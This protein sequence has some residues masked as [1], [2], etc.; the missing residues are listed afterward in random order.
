MNDLTQ[1]L[2][3]G[4]PQAFADLY[5]AMADQLHHYLTARTG[6]TED[7][8][9]LLQ[10]TFSR[11]F[12]ARGRLSRVESLTAYVFQTARNEYI[13]W[14]GQR[15]GKTVS[16]ELLFEEASLED[17]RHVQTAEM[18]AGALAHLPQN[19]REVVELKTYARLTFHEI[20]EVMK[21]PQGTVA[22]WYRRALA[23][24]R[25]C[26]EDESRTRWAK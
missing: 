5:D 9:D 4:Q 1:R 19:Y 24:M 14:C 12:R 11:L 18:I 17:E 8:S 20:A 26:L 22:T 13:R 2:A 21:K 10:E 7:A 25:M 15:R 16:A 3:A 23:Q 6:S